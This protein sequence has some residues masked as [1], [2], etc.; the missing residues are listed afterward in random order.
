MGMSHSEDLWFR[1]SRIDK[2]NFHFWEMLHTTRK[3][4]K[5]GFQPI[6]QLHPKR[7]KVWKNLL[8]VSNAYKTIWILKEQRFRYYLLGFVPY[9]THKSEET[10]TWKSHK[11]AEISMR[12]VNRMWLESLLSRN[13]TF[14]T[15]TVHEIL[16]WTFCK[17]VVLFSLIIL[18]LWVP[19]IRH[20]H[21]PE[22]IP[23]WKSSKTQKLLWVWRT[24]F[25]L[26]LLGARFWV[27]PSA[28]SWVC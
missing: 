26:F 21:K 22:V 8:Y 2:G 6:F 17:V 27:F 14:R 25:L 3:W 16:L 28:A 20:N 24:W 7:M 18:S 9:L 11:I 5:G 19:L 1:F 15:M 10:P 13:S 12:L 23:N 4:L